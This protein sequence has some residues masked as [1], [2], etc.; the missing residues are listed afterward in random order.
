VTFDEE[1]LMR[2]FDGDLDG[3]EA[4]EMERTLADS[5]EARALLADFEQ[6]GSEI[7]AIAEERGT[8]AGLIVDHVMANL[9][10]VPAKRGPGAGG[11]LIRLAPV[12]GVAL[13]AAAPVGLL[14]PSH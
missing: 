1:R 8:R 4:R 10:P 2:Y 9:E 3:E 12:V 7:R 5:P 13:A 6:V 14:V 11:R